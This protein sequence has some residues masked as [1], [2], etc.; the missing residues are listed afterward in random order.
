MNKKII[1][2]PGEWFSNKSFLQFQD[3][4][5]YP[6]CSF[7]RFTDDALQTSTVD[8]INDDCE[9]E[10]ERL[11]DYTKLLLEKSKIEEVA[12]AMESNELPSKLNYANVSSLSLSE[13]NIARI[14]T[15]MGNEDISF[16]RIVIANDKAISYKRELKVSFS[17]RIA[18]FGNKHL[19]NLFQDKY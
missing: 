16:I 12:T 2:I 14:C 19:L 3:N 15:N 7:T 8:D 5:C 13:E 10:G 1:Q 18:T 11:F 4:V 17:D 6:S 9:A